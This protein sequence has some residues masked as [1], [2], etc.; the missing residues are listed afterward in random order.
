MYLCVLRFPWVCHSHTL[1]A[2]N[3]L[4]LFHELQYTTQYM[5]L[6]VPPLRCLVYHFLTG[7]CTIFYLVYRISFTGVYHSARYM[8]HLLDFVLYIP[9]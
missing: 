5:P 7:R 4:V 9:F 6:H 8:Y 1:G 3:P 2:H